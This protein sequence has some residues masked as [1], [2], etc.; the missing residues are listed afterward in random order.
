MPGPIKSR[1]VPGTKTHPN[2]E[3]AE[4]PRSAT[5]CAFDDLD[6]AVAEL[7]DAYSRLNAK[8]HPVM[9]PTCGATSDDCSKEISRGSSPVVARIENIC[10]VIRSIHYAVNE[11]HNSLEI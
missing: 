5:E 7:G 11:T 6:R 4:R 10:S 9:S 2:N 3:V 1:E 8:L